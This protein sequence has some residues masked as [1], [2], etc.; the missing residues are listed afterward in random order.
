MTVRK[1]ENNSS[2]VHNIS[3]KNIDKFE[4]KL[5]ELNDNPAIRNLEI[6][7]LISSEKDILQFNN[8]YA[9]LQSIYS[10]CF[11]KVNDFISD[12]NFIRKPWITLAIAK[13][14]LT[15]KQTLSYKSQA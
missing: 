13:S 11:L 6:D 1:E 15:K 4:A 14:C 10:E 5:V 8:Y 9:R 3:A 7:D 12:R 2:L